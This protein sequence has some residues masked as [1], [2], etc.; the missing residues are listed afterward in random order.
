MFFV[1]SVKL[2][3]GVRAAYLHGV[4]SVTSFRLLGAYITAISISLLLDPA[5]LT[6]LSMRMSA[7]GKLHRV[8][9]LAKAISHLIK[10]RAYRLTCHLPVQIPQ[11][12]SNL[13]TLASS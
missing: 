7:L 2:D 10:T 6:G 5:L 9:E 1:G 12:S 8:P 4:E 13:I 11:S 3:Q